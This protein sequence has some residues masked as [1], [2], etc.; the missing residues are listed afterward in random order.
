MANGSGRHIA[1]NSSKLLLS[2]PS[3]LSG[4]QRPKMLSTK[5]PT[6]QEAAQAIPSASTGGCALACTTA[7][8]ATLSAGK[9][10]ASYTCHHV[11]AEA[12]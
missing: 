7:L 2:A 8:C 5:T 12:E 4:S 9:V 11:I 10:P 3:Y 6:G 1:T